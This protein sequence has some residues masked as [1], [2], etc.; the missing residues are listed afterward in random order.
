MD[1]PVNVPLALLCRLCAV[2]HRVFWQRRTCRIP[3]PFQRASV[4]GYSPFAGGLSSIRVYNDHFW[5]IQKGQGKAA[6]PSTPNTTFSA[7]GYIK[8]R[9]PPSIKVQRSCT[10]L[11]TVSS[12]VV[13]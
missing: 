4:S 3:G 2:Y 13:L 9:L 6:A 5:Q 11:Y 10:C 1:S 7:A 8:Q 12:G